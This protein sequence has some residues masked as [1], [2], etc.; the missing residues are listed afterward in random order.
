[1]N[2]VKRVRDGKAR[3]KL[4]EEYVKGDLFTAFLK[5]HNRGVGWGEEVR[6]LRNLAHILEGTR[7]INL[8]E[9]QRLQEVGG[10]NASLRRAIG[11]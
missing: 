2:N 8:L 1:M 7:P 9:H 6:N 4:L 3:E 11:C 5:G 10:V